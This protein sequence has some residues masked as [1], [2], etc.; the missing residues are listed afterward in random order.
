MIRVFSL[1]LLFLL[2][3]QLNIS[4]QSYS[5][6][7]SCMDDRD[8]AYQNLSRTQILFT[9]SGI[10]NIS[11]VWDLNHDPDWHTVNV[12]PIPDYSFHS[13]SFDSLNRVTEDISIKR[14]SSSWEYLLDLQYTYDVTGNMTYTLTR[15]YV[16][17]HWVNNSLLHLDYNVQNKMILQEYQTWN[18]TSWDN[19]SKTE[20]F[21][22][23][24]GNDTLS[25]QY[26]GSGTTWTF[27]T[28]II[29]HY[30]QQNILI[31][32][33]ENNWNN[34]SWNN[35]RKT[36]IYF[37]SAG[38]DTLNISFDG[39]DSV[40]VNRMMLRK[41]YSSFGLEDSLYFTWNGT[42]WDNDSRIQHM[43]QNINEDTLDVFYSG[44]HLLWDTT[45]IYRKSY[46]A[47]S[48]LAS[49]SVRLFDSINSG[50]VFENFIYSYDST[51]NSYYTFKQIFDTST[52]TLVNTTRTIYTP[53]GGDSI[54]Y[55][56]NWV[57]TSW[58]YSYYVYTYHS[59]RSYNYS[60]G[61]CYGD[62]QGFSCDVFSDYGET[63][64]S[65]GRLI[66]SSWSGH[67]GSSGGFHNWSYDSTGFLFEEHLFGSTMGGLTHSLD[68]YHYH[69]LLSAIY[70]YDPIACNGDSVLL[71]SWVA[72][73]ES[74]YYYFWYDD[75]VL[76]DSSGS[77]TNVLI[78]GNKKYFLRVVDSYGNIYTDSIHIN[79]SPDFTL[80]NDKLVCNTSSI[81]LTPDHSLFAYHWQDGSSDS[82]FNAF[83]TSNITDTISYWL[84][85]YDSI[86]CSN[87]DTITV[88]FDVCQSIE[89]PDAINF[90]IFPN[91]ITHGNNLTMN[92]PLNSSDVKIVSDLGIKIQHFENVSGEFVIPFNYAAG[93]YFIQLAAKDYFINKKLVVE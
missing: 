88:I 13:Y 51:Q 25:L 73:G 57:D 6:I 1:L 65:A 90:T 79:R 69:P 75:N 83:T 67:T 46:D 89:N 91:P 87:T 61:N 80:G 81:A 20:I 27:F 44:N 43:Y 64:D 15:N 78:N 11:Q 63:Y 76:I 66:S 31:S 17:N 5:T 7:D 21:Y 38:H 48:N 62:C 72:G 10:Y 74:P 22:D 19:Q 71:Q 2:S 82:S 37:D 86:G 39:H 93:I 55:V 23:S 40:W 49:T 42:A 9:D 24:I 60:D 18:G 58:C 12:D 16:L 41:I 34:I 32:T 77:M 92:L 52:M 30:N 59:P 50:H 4:A 35:N 85:G 53:S 70:N 47:F 84:T 8:G 29:K 26:S 68:C 14:D 36:E 3:I 45:T 54:I 28:R 33:E 56:S